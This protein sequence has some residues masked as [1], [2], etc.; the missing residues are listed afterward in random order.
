LID[1]VS[2]PASGSVTPKQVFCSPR[3]S[4]GSQARRCSSVPNTTTGAGRRC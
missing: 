4:G 2:R 1:V 3:M